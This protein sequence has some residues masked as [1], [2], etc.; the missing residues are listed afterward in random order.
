MLS[1]TFN[2]NADFHGG[3]A[4]EL[5]VSSGA[6]IY[7]RVERSVG[8]DSRGSASILGIG[9][10]FTLF[11]KEP[12]TDY[13]AGRVRVRMGDDLH[14]EEP[15]DFRDKYSIV[16]LLGPVYEG[17]WRGESATVAWGLEAYP[18][19]ALVNAYALNAYSADHDIAGAKTTLLYYGYYYGYG[20]SAVAR[21][22]AGVGPV[23]IGTAA[24]LSYH[25]SIEG[26]DRY[27]EELDGDVHATDTWYRFDARLGVPLPGTPV[28][29]EATGRWSRRRGSLGDTTAH[30]SESRYSLG[31]TWRM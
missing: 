31:L 28:S 18:D 8:G 20:A 21:L 25:E 5:D 6:V 16:H 1:S 11:R 2:I 12:V 7:G 30:G 4:Q 15:R 17:Y 27:E 9:S 10:A 24:S 22:E 29:V 26:L 3:T 14:L 19:F 23:T 13:D